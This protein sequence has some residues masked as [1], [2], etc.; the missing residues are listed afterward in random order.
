VS[1]QELQFRIYHDALAKKNVSLL[2]TSPRYSSSDLIDY[3]IELTMPI[4]ISSGNSSSQKEQNKNDDTLVSAR[5]IKRSRL[6]QTLNAIHQDRNKQKIF[7]FTFKKLQNETQVVRIY[8]ANNPKST[9]DDDDDDD[10]S[11]NVKLEKTNMNDQNKLN[12]KNETY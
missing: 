8:L 12:E 10:H 3:E 9:I 1:D 2:A 4:D 11:E 7:N 6:A 5:E